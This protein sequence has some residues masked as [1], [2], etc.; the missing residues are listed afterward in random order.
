MQLVGAQKQPGS[1]GLFWCKGVKPGI[2]AVAKSN[3]GYNG[4]ISHLIDSAKAPGV[5][6]RQMS[7]SRRVN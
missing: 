7:L 3:R 6:I 1:V 4:D 5:R 2:E